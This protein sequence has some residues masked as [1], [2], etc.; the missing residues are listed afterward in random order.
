MSLVEPGTG[1]RFSTTSEQRQTAAA[2]DG[3]VG[4]GG[5]GR[6][7]AFGRLLNEAFRARRWKANLNPAHFVAGITRWRSRHCRGPIIGSKPGLGGNA[8]RA[9]H[10][11][12]RNGPSAFSELI[13][14]S[15]AP[16]AGGPEGARSAGDFE[17]QGV[18]R[19]LP[20]QPLRWACL[21]HRRAG[22]RHR[23]AGQ[24]CS[25]RPAPASRDVIRPFPDEAK[26]RMRLLRRWRWRL[27]FEEQPRHVD[28]WETVGMPS[29]PHEWV[30][31][32]GF[33]SNNA[34][35]VVKSGTSPG[36]VP[37]GFGGDLEPGGADPP[38]E[39]TKMPAYRIRW[40]DK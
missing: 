28:N 1:F 17:A 31:R 6:P 32:V 7:T 22:Y 18:E 21:R 36:P 38:V 37:S 13:D 19:R 4:P 14:P 29:Q 39:A 27:R 30:K 33:A 5:A 12:G 20:S 26:R 25:N 40:R 8:F 11:P 9:V 35:A 10:R 34:D 2:R 16:A 24:C 15:P 23:P 3:R